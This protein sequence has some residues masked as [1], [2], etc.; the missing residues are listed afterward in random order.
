MVD[1]C[2]QHPSTEIVVVCQERVCLFFC[3]CVC[4]CASAC[5]CVWV[6][7]QP[8]TLAVCYFDVSFLFVYAHTHH[9]CRHDLPRAHVLTNLLCFLLATKKIQLFFMTDNGNSQCTHIENTSDAQ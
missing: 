2:T 4:V 6:C 7:T 8:H 9:D 3:T 5:W 1:V